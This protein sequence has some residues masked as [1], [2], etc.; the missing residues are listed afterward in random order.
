MHFVGLKY[1]MK[2]NARYEQQ[3]NPHICYDCSYG[4]IT[5]KWIPRQQNCQDDRWNIESLTNTH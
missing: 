3:K 5:V 1:G 2:E 4:I